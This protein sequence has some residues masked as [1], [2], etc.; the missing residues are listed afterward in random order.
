[1]H[2]PLADVFLS[3]NPKSFHYE[4]NIPPYYFTSHI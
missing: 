4:K 3:L 1:M 2:P